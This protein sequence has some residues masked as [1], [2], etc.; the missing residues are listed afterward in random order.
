[1][2][3]QLP[4]CLR[5]LMEP[6]RYKVLRGGRG[7]GG[8]SWGCA[9]AMIARAL[10]RKTLILCAR[11]IQKSIKES[12][13]RLLS[14]QIREMGVESAFTITDQTIKNN[15]N[16][17]EFIFEGL[18]RNV[19]RIK[20]IEGVDICFVEEAENVSAESW[21]YLVPTIR[22]DGS[23][24]W[25]VFNPRYE[26]DA[27]YQR[28]VVNPPPDCISK[29]L[30]WY[31]NPWFPEVL[32]QEMEYCRKTNYEEYKN[33]WLGEVR[34]IGA[35][36]WH[37]Y[38]EKVHVRDFP[39]ERIKEW[40]NC[41]MGMDPHSKYYPFCVWVAV[42]P[43][44]D[45]R[46][47]FYKVVYNEWPRFDDLGGYY[48]DLRTKLYYTGTIADIARAIYIADGKSEW[49]INVRK[50]FLD[51]RF[52]K[53]SGGTNWSTST[54]GIVSEFAKRDNGGLLFDLPA[55]RVI[56]VQRENIL[57]AMWFNKLA[58][59]NKFNEPDLIVL[60]HCRNVRQSLLNHRC[61]EGSEVEDEKFKDPSDALRICWAGMDGERYRIPNR[62]GKEIDDRMR[63]IFQSE[64]RYSA[65]G[66]WMA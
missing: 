66:G 23:E 21:D 17:S 25:V 40:G 55:E 9:R 39:M 8:K 28:F 32:K 22:K 5:F 46:E 64:Y 27:T 33:I 56:D 57:K 43:K 53:G 63:G 58:P 19:T 35:K 14:D 26:D 3:L 31:D 20:S 61:E 29:K 54:V 15:M 47:S 6:H 13:H 34:G 4:E 44:D 36:I 7:A 2:E 42:V 16:G 65:E 37:Q 11:E 48:S 51:T 1:M 41:Y 38:D 62:A 52:A 24:I 18:F 12:V 30:M 50:R 59:V 60:P 49:G 45:N 10:S